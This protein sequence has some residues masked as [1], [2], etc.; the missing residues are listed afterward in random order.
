MVAPGP[1]AGSGVNEF[2]PLLPKAG[3]G[4]REIR[5]PVGDVMEALA[6][7]LEESAHGGIGSQRLNDLDGA[8]KADSDALGLQGF[9]RGTGRSR[10]ELEK[11]ASLLQGGHGHGDVVQWV[12]KHI[13]VVAWMTRRQDPGGASTPAAWYRGP[14]IRTRSSLHGRQ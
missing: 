6:A 5:D 10:Q 7:V 12:G 3:Q 13:R 4:F 2:D 9:H 8:G 11:T 14:P 1:E